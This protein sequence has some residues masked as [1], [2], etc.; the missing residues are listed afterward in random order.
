[1][2][3]NSSYWRQSENLLLLSVWMPIVNSVRVLP[4]GMDIEAVQHTKD[5]SSDLAVGNS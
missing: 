5:A 4:Y 1:M 3:L 2:N